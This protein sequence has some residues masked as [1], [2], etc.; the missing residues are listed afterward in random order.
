MTVKKK[1]TKRLPNGFWSHNRRVD[2]Y[3]RLKKKFGPYSKWT[4]I[5]LPP[6]DNPAKDLENFQ[7]EMGN[8]YQHLVG[9][10]PANWENK[11]KS[12]N[13]QLAFAVTTQHTLTGTQVLNWMGN[14]IAAKEAG[15]ITN[16]HVSDLV[17]K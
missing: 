3:T 4:S 13:N 17:L 6:T 11:C 2:Y 1:R 14:V 10:S 12:V 15:F 7:E 8:L 5:N 16:K 9:I